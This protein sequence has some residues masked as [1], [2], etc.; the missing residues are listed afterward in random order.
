MIIL[1][2]VMNGAMLSFLTWCWSDLRG[3]RQARR[4]VLLYAA[5]ILANL[6]GW[7]VL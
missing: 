7:C 5:L 2:I 3:E 4:A 1:L 6:L